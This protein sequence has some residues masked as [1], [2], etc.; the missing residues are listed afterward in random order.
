MT[1]QMQRVEENWRENLGVDAENYKYD[2]VTADSVSKQDPNK[3]PRETLEF[4]LF[5]VPCPSIVISYLCKFVQM[6]I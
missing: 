4:A 5:G 2:G 3:L 1:E 6:A